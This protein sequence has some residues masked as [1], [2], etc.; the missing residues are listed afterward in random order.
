MDYENLS[1]E[2][3]VEVL[4]ELEKDGIEL[5][6]ERKELEER[7]KKAKAD[8]ENYRKKED[9]RKQ[10][11]Q[12][13]A[14]EELAEELIEVLDNLERAIASAEDDSGIVKGVKMV[15]DQLYEKLEKKGLERIN[16]EG[17]EFDPRM[18]KA[19]ETREHDKEN[20]ILE[21]KRKG[22][23]FNDK[24]LREAEVVVG[25]SDKEE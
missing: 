12:K 25:K 22:Y 19:V 20:R 18:H 24:V 2:K 8:F 23:M 15:S 17:E 14:E 21:Q 9:E 13:Q 4:E 1:K 5:E 10:R 7:A 16:A 3:L 11:W 6:K